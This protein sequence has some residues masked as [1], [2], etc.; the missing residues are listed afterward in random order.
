M[1]K[2]G[3]SL[4]AHNQQTVH[5]SR[6]HHPLKNLFTPPTSNNTLHKPLPK[7][8]KELRPN[9]IIQGEQPKNDTAT[10]TKRKTPR[11]TK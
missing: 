3:S 6:T 9:N 10:N 7:G 11:T 5:L 8:I 2:I 4:Q 1:F